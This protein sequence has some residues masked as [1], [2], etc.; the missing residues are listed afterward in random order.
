VSQS[1]FSL[2]ATISESIVDFIIFIQLPFVHVSC[3]TGQKCFRDKVIR[4][5][6]KDA[7]VVWKDHCE[8]H[9]AFA[10]MMCDDAFVRRIGTVQD[11]YLKK[12]SRMRADLKAFVKAKKNHPTPKFNS[13]GEPQ[14][15]G[16]RVQQLLKEMV[17]E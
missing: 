10:R 8:N 4:P 16:S 1:S 5:D 17:S 2:V 14:W 11:D 15:H 7:K 6:Y 13:R 3:S 9:P 12:L